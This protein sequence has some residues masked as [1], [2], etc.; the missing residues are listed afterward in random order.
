M[1]YSRLLYTSICSFI[2]FPQRLKNQEITETLLLFPCAVVKLR[3][4]ITYYK[5]IFYI[6]LFLLTKQVNFKQ[7]VLLYD[8]FS[9][10]IISY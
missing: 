10:H 9:K 8:K 6:L 2:L 5:K 1:I 7:R 3:E 4:N